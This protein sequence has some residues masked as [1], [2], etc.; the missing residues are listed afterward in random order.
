M[1]LLDTHT[2]LWFLSNSP[3]LSQ[4]AL[5]AICSD[6]DVY[7]SYASLW[8][9]S[10]KKSLGKLRLNHNERKIQRYPRSYADCAVIVAN[11]REKLIKQ[12][13]QKG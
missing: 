12:K 5:K 9:I 4:N 13:M 10:I 7:V 11:V 3:E 2:L 6:T 8:E 1:Y